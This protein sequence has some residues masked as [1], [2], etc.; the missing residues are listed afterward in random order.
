M[1]QNSR[2]MVFSFKMCVCVCMFCFFLIYI[3]INILKFEQRVPKGF[4]TFLPEDYISKFY[5]L[6][7]LEVQKNI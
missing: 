6:L 1:L 2:I 5:G 3:A 4:W 7:E